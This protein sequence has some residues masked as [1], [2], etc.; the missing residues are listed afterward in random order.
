MNGGQYDIRRNDTVN[1]GVGGWM[2]EFGA[3]PDNETGAEVVEFSLGQMDNS[4]HSWT[5]WD[6]PADMK[7]LLPSLDRPYVSSVWGQLLSMQYSQSP[8]NFSFSYITPDFASDSNS[9]TCFIS[10]VK[11]PQGEFTV[12][13]PAGIS[14][15]SIASDC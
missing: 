12:H 15:S 7:F 13:L 5:Y 9:T 10:G 3:L 8:R 6:A 14:G 1:L 2:S 4:L 11:F